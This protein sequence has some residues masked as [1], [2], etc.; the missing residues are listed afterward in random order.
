MEIR[1][2]GD[3]VHGRFYVKENNET[4]A[5]MTYKWKDDDVFIIEHTEVS[6]ALA[7]KGVGKQL[8]NAAVEFARYGK[9]RVITACPFAR[10]VFEKTPAYQDVL[11]R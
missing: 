11:Y 6:E 3:E 4:L 9:H 8:V 7:G 10:S 1:H 2:E 5:E